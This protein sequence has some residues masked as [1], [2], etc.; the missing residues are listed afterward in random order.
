MHQN[1]ISKLL[2]RNFTAFRELDI[3]FSPGINVFLGANG[4]GKTHLLKIL[5]TLIDV[6]RTKDSLITITGKLLKVFLPSE[7]RMG[8][9]AHRQ[10]GS[11]WASVELH[12]GKRKIRV[13]FSNHAKA[14]TKVT[15]KDDWYQ[16]KIECAYIPVKEML[17]HAPGFR[18]LYSDREIHFEEI[19]S[20]IVDR[21]FRPILR[22]PM[23][24]KR[25][26]LLEIL[27]RAIQGKVVAKGEEFFLQDRQGN[28]EFTLLAEGMRK[29]ALLWLLIQNG[30][31]LRG[32]ILFWDE[33]EANLN[34][35]MI[36]QIIEILLELQRTGVQIFLATHDYVVLKQLDLQ[37]ETSDSVK[38]HS[39]F[40]KKETGEIAICST[41][42]YISIHPNAIADTFMDLYDRD[43]ERVIEKNKS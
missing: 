14:K 22:G 38:F 43:I 29:L 5:Y 12:R 23:E 15:W 37:K 26:R 28:L 8:R 13:K 1:T 34:P 2:I 25:K 33:P 16:E 3:D 11:I 40:R 36:G 24:E 4:T 31:L 10:R 30:T 19:Y 41:E 20:D 17:A 27:E 42:D 7:G 18:S 39:L 32:S 35:K 9:L 21:A 6:T